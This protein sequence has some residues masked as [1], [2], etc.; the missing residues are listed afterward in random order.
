VVVVDQFTQAVARAVLPLHQI[1]PVVAP[2]L[3]FRRTNFLPLRIHGSE[4]LALLLVF[5]FSLCMFLFIWR[6]AWS[7]LD[8]VAALAGLLGGTASSIADVLNTGLSTHFLFTQLP[9][10]LR[11]ETNVEAIAFLL[12]GGYILL[13]VL[14]GDVPRL[15][16]GSDRPHRYRRRDH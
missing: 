6:G 8:V 3:G 1:V 5:V 14:T 16:L 4:V 10:G 13:R 7:Q 9:L 11:I 2:W 15:G 12:G